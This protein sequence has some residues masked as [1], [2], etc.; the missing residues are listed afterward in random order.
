MVFLDTPGWLKPIDPFQSTMKRAIV[1]SIY[2]DADVLMWMLEP[3]T[4]TSEDEDFALKL[5]NTRKPLCVAINKTDLPTAGALIEQMVPALKAQLGGD[6][7]IHLIS[8]KNQTGLQNLKKD[9][10]SKLPLSPAYFPTDQ[11][12]DRWERFYVAEL[13]REEIF[14]RY[15]QEV[16]HASTVIIEEFVEK[17]GRKDVIQVAIVV[18][19]EG[20]MK[21][22]VGQKGQAI[23]VLGQA[24][25]AE[26]EARL[27][28][29]VFLE[30]KVKV[31]KNWRKDPQ[32]L[33]SIKT[34][35]L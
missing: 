19:T 14:R 27:G 28:R 15:Q 7:T 4:L 35:N 20:Q 22:V 11:V 21:I 6:V 18:E 1:R 17:P 16:P 32:F 12:T 31:R 34:Q 10:A 13:I 8:A 25:R 5:K 9:L 33:E 29:P 3:K 30:L 23:K 24:A 2:D 26:I